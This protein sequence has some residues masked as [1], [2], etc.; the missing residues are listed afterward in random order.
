MTTVAE[1]ANLLNKTMGLSADTVGL[2]VIEYAVKTRVSACKSKNLQDYWE[3]VH[4]CDGELQEL[5]DEVI[6]PETWFFRD[7]E[8]FAGLAN[9]AYNRWLPLHAEG[10]LRLLS[11][12]CATGEEPYSMAMALL[13]AG[14][15]AGLFRIDA[16]DISPRLLKR[17]GQA[18]YGKNSFRGKGLEF[19]DRFFE[20]VGSEFRVADAVRAQ[21]HFHHGNM[22]DPLFAPDT[23]AYDFIFC[24]NVLIY[25]DRDTQDRAVQVLTRLLKAD[26]VLYVGPSESGLM[27]NNDFA[28]EKLALAF[29]FRKKAHTAPGL[30]PS[31]ARLPKPR[32]ATARGVPAPAAKP[33]VKRVAPARP[34]A[35]IAQP[36]AAQT[37][38]DEI[39]RFANQGRLG[40]ALQRGEEFL[41]TCGPS[42]QA[43]HLMGLVHD[44]TGMHQEAEQYYRKA[45][46]LDPDHHEA[47]VH[48]AFLLE[49]QGDAAGAQRLHRRAKRL[50][51]GG[52]A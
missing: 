28:S 46:Y 29:A 50:S 44:A 17:A 47:L 52:R 41:Q 16:I 34:A 19:R 22:L 38:L 6:V 14:V 20:P 15:P 48:L 4:A 40:E 31:A 23:A 2:S 24:R 43:Y 18:V 25:F 21:V 26:G 1:F 35:A 11:L 32:R 37:G 39:S 5:I 51:A 36:V 33:V 3:H 49:Q 7:R 9:E 12:P 30:D 42:V 13:A 8:A 45:L 27:L 10:Q